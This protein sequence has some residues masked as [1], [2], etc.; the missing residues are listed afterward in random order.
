MTA[1]TMQKFTMDIP[2]NIH[3]LWTMFFKSN[4][5]GVYMTD[6]CDYLEG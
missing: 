2:F 1:V 5:W 6:L 3:S 4:F